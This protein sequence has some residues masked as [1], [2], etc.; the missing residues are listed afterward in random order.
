MKAAPFLLL[1]LP[2]LALAAGTTTDQITMKPQASPTCTSGRACIYAK[3]G[4]DRVYVT[5]SAGLE[6]QSNAARSFRTSADCTAL[7]SPANG[8]VCYSSGLGTF[9]FYA[10]GW[11]SA[12]ANDSLL[13][14]K[15]G[16]ETITGVKNFAA[17]PVFAAGLT[18]SGAVPNDFSGSTGPFKT[19]TGAATIGPGTISLTGALALAGYPH[20]FLAHADTAAATVY[21]GGAD[22]GAAAAT[23]IAL[24]VAPAAGVVRGLTCTEGTAPGGIVSDVFT[25]Q[26]SSNQGA[27]WSDTTSTATITGAALTA[28]DVTHFPTVAQYDWLAVKILKDGASASAVYNCQVLVQ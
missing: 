3:S 5:D 25:V 28:A 11:T 4:T 2:A 10:A 14:H 1:L 27:A 7:S 17:A 16:S 26:K 21:L 23:Q 19:S 18:A 20:S 12:P 24:F 22:R 9:Q 6:L 13:V 8:D 15:A